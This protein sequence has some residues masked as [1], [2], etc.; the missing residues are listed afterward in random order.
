M[1]IFMALY[2][3]IVYVVILGG[4]YGKI[5]GLLHQFPHPGGHQLA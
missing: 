1:V 2:N 3:I 5:Q 4:H